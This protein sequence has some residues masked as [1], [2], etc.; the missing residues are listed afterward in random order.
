MSRGQVAIIGMASVFPRAPR[1]A[2]FWRL[3][4]EGQSALEEGPPHRL[5]PQLYD[6]ESEDP[7]RY[8]TRRGGFIDRFARFDPLRFGVMPTAARGAEPDQ[9]LTL[10]ACADAL[11]DAGY[12]R[13]TGRPFSPQ[14]DV[15]LGRGGYI[16]PGMTNL[17]LRVR[18]LEQLDHTLSELGLLDRAERAELRA[19]FASKLEHFGADTAIGLVPNLTAARVA[20]RLNLKGSAYTIDAACAS[21]LL[22]V[23]RACESLQSGR[24]DLALAGGVHLVHDLTFWSVFTQLGALSRGHQIQPFSEEADG[25]L[26]GEGLGVLVLKR[27]QEA[28]KDGDRVYAV[29]E[30]VGS[31]SDGKSATL[32]SPSV[33]G[34]KSALKRAWSELEGR[35]LGL[36]EAHATATPVGDRAELE[37]IKHFFGEREHGPP[38]A[39]GTLKAM[40]GHTMPA[41]GAAALIKASL[42]VYH[43]VL[44]PSSP[45]PDFKPH[46]LLREGRLEVIQSAR[47]WERDRPRRAAVNAFG[48]GGSNAHVIVCHPSELDLG[49][50]FEPTP[51]VRRPLL[52]H[53]QAPRALLALAAE[54]EDELVLLIEA[55]A[56]RLESAR[57]QGAP[58]DHL[59]DERGE[60]TD[61]H[62]EGRGPHRVALTDPSAERLSALIKSVRS[63]KPKR[64]RGGLWSI[65]PQHA[66]WAD[67]PSEQRTD[68]GY[69]QVA[70]LYP[71]V[72]AS[73]APALDGLCV[74]LGHP[75]PQLFQSDPSGGPLSPEGLA[76]RGVGVIRAGLSLTAALETLNV[77]PQH[78]AG[79]SLGE[80]TGLV[81]AGYLDTAQ[82]DAFIQGLDPSGL[83]VPE[84]TFIAVGASR[85]RVEAVLGSR[86]GLYCSHANCPH[87]SVFCAPRSEAQRL[88]EELTA[89]QLVA[90]QLPFESGFHAPYFKPYASRITQHLRGLP[91]RE[92]HTPL[93]SS[94]TCE[95]Y[96]SLSA[97]PEAFYQLSDRHLTEPVR[98]QALTERLY[99]E[100]VRVFIQLGVG[101]L[102]SFVSDT[103]RGRPHL[104]IDAHSE[105]HGAREQLLRLCGALFAEGFEPDLSPLCPPGNP[106]ER[107]MA[108]KLGVPIIS[109][110]DEGE[111]RETRDA[112]HRS[113]PARVNP[114]EGSDAQRGWSAPR[115]VGAWRGV[116]SM[117]GPLQRTKGAQGAH[118]RASWSATWRLSIED[119][120]YLIDHCFF[121]QPAGWPE[122]RDRFPVVPMTLSIQWVM[123][124][125]QFVATQS[126]LRARVIAVESV[127]ASRWVEVAPPNMVKVSAQLT[128]AVEG[129][130]RVRVELE[131]HLSAVVILADHPPALPA[132]HPPRRLKY[133]R[134]API[135][136]SQVYR[137]RWM[138]H[139]PAYEAIDELCALSPEGIRGVL[140]VTDTPGAL[141][142]NVGQLFGL[143]VML[144]EEEDR[145]VMPVSLDSLTLYGPPPQRGERLPCV[146]WVEEL[147]KRSVVAHMAIWRGER[148]W[149]TIRGWRDWRFE[150][151]GA[152]WGLMQYPERSLY[153]QPCAP[154]Q[155]S[156]EMSEVSVVLARGVS[157][158]ASSRE[159]LVGRCLNQE[160]Q[161]YYRSQ[162]SRVQRGWL[163]GRIAAKD[164]ARVH[165]WRLRGAPT[166]ASS[167]SPL[168]PIEVS[169]MSVASGAIAY[170][171]EGAGAGL[172][173]SI[174]HKEGLAVAVSAL[175]STRVGVDL[176]PIEARPQSW[177]EV[178]FNERERRL[179]EE[180]GQMG[181]DLRYTIAWCAKEAV[182]KMTGE[183]LGHPKRWSLERLEGAEGQTE[184]VVWVQ[185]HSVTWWRVEGDEGEPL[186][187]SLVMVASA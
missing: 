140:K 47:A 173:V 17:N 6:P 124:T 93:W 3:L 132:T 109:L 141:L 171:P 185:G 81:G 183:G 111:P 20:Q 70:F 90:Q 58:W 102:S 66:L 162:S 182:A 71:G 31:S 23:E 73:F 167:R 36:L 21:A 143:W 156:P 4:L 13:P 84:V 114:S 22:S 110:H 74:H 51:I 123:E 34:Q 85:E 10:Q 94:T 12:G 61:S 62:R 57:A 96:P 65:P 142:D 146:V 122:L 107:S 175:E 38:I 24:S 95:R 176:E 119:Q 180:G 98:F 149:A 177:R 187:V 186:V 63:G 37:T 33:E 15:I 129:T 150:T 27:Y 170:H 59:V 55:W 5:P 126:G 49:Q 117:P 101:S 39:L 56:R 148:L 91:L 157:A 130:R 1:L 112:R 78:L 106:G 164:A 159:F 104:A 125:A 136:A 80:W 113:A 86:A 144:T 108:L 45:S 30:G 154:A 29:I 41:S 54:S 184:G 153:A 50:G 8:Y 83:E 179:I 158:V 75:A 7:A 44:T 169:T 99:Q 116:G 97:D 40:I 16:G 48:F 174:A 25:L 64:G 138:F 32:M 120:P 52:S 118:E 115:D 11:L 68:E 67:L 172:S 92:P 60:L 35:D 166:G 87:Q 14:T 128:P 145:V 9:L 135:T 178:S 168:Y 152:L 131:G 160:E 79:H 134:P 46:P 82:V 165:L 121:R 19:R 42:S 2:S 181:L 133:E 69:A 151:S 155:Q 18:T 163:A 28:L 89:S 26:I 100:G 105:H 139:G 137:D 76:K 72:E 103:L 53:L 77:R 161:A 147:D 43:G 127:K 88:I